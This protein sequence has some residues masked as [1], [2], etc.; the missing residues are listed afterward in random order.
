MTIAMELICIGGNAEESCIHII[1]RK[2]PR[3]IPSKFLT[4]SEFRFIAWKILYFS[5]LHIKKNKT[6]LSD[7]IFIRS[8]IIHLICLKLLI[9]F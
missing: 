8:R 7:C 2:G 4:Y 6:T 9:V 5:I 3:K 1:F